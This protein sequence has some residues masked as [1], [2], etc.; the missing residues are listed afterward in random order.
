MFLLPP[1]LI[2]IDDLRRE[3]FY[4]KKI[5]DRIVINSAASFLPV[6]G[7]QIKNKGY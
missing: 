4:S 2:D 5:G 1:H 6:K 3:L 7:K